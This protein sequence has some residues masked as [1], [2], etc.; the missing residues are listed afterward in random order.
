[1]TS[2]PHDTWVSQ[3]ANEV[4]L[5]RYIGENSFSERLPPEIVQQNVSL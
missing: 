1:M 3:F 5:I 2:I 4:L